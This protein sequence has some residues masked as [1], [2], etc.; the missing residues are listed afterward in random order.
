MY[1]LVEFLFNEQKMSF[2]NCV[3][4]NICIY[5]GLTKCFLRLLVEHAYILFCEEFDRFLTIFY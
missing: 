4:M 5:D 1:V 2:P 3:P